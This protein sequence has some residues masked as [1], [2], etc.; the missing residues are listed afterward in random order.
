MAAILVDSGASRESKAEDKFRLCALRETSLCAHQNSSLRAPSSN[1]LVSFQSLVNTW[2]SLR[3][4]TQTARIAMDWIVSTWVLSVKGAERVCG[5][6]R[7][8]V[9]VASRRGLAGS[10]LR[11]PNAQATIERTQCIKNAPRLMPAKIERSSLRFWST[12][13]MKRERKA[14]RLAELWSRWLQTTTRV[15]INLCIRFHVPGCQYIKGMQRIIWRR[16]EGD[17]RW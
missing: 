4:Y 2:A 14:G 3:L 11:E 1:H 10:E 16:C 13:E 5:E 9:V 8:S 6:V 17:Y 15:S 12:D 7:M